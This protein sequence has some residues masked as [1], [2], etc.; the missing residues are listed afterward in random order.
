MIESPTPSVRVRFPPSPTG[1]MH[2]GNVRTFLFNYLFARQRGGTIVFRS[3]DTDRER[4]RSEYEDAILQNLAWLGLTYDEGPFRQSERTALYET[5]FEKL[6]AAD[7]IYPAY[8]TPAE[9]DAERAAQAA[10][11]EPPRY[12]G[13]SRDLTPGERAAYEAEGRQPVW[14]VRVPDHEISFTDMIRGTISEQG[15]NVSDFVIRKADGQFLYHFCVVVDDIEMRITHIIRGEDH[16]SNTTKHLVLYSALGAPT[17]T[18]AHIPLLLNT[19]RSKMSKRDA[20]GKPLTL[21]RLREEG[22]LQSTIINYLALLGWSP[23]NGETREIFS[24]TELTELFDITRVQKAGAIFDFAKLTHFNAQYIRALPLPELIALLRP[25]LDFPI[26]NE[27]TLTA[28]VTLLH[29]RIQLFSEAP[30]LLR[31]FFVTPEPAPDLFANEKMKVTKESSLTA[32]EI[33]A[34]FLPSISPWNE[35]H[36]KEKLF[37]LA[38]DKGLKNGQLLWPLRV[39]LTSQLYSPGAF[40]VA[41][42]LGQNETLSR[43]KKSIQALAPTA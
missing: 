34:D 42:V 23:G 19:D 26:D 11:K 18:Y 38:L 28:A 1:D 40:E 13:Y 17:P 8:E 2:I 32:L 16:I 9:L 6:K 35:E 37:A 3:E 22:Y 5:Y 30:T 29:D 31:Y 15:R 7:A 20:T 21:T 12:I 41:A 33:L 39:A 36:L 14:R 43:I 25:L 4:S 10:R 27:D 24:L